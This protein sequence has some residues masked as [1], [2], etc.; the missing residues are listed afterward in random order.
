MILSY[1]KLIIQKEKISFKKMKYCSNDFIFIPIQYNKQD[2]LIQTPHC[3]VPFG[4]NQYSTVSKKK[5]LDLSFQE[6][7]SEFITNCFDV[8]YQKVI[9]Q[10]SSKYQVESFLKENQYSKYMMRFKV[11]D[12]CL[13]FDQHKKKIESFEP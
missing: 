4:F 12:D 1:K 2:I 10:Y 11:D 13:L 5:Y 6:N 3:F 9:E 8:F 7:H